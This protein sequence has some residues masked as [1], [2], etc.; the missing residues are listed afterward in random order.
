MCLCMPIA[1]RIHNLLVVQMVEKS[2]DQENKWEEGSL[3][4]WQMSTRRVVAA[5]AEQPLHG[6]VETEVPVGS[7]MVVVGPGH[8]QV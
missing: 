5:M 6:T 1:I 4:I 2:N 7:K 3:T 8:P